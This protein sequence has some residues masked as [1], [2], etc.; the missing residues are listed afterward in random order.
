MNTSTNQS[1]SNGRA[2]AIEH[3]ITVTGS[4]AT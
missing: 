2:Y 1:S 3:R 4:T